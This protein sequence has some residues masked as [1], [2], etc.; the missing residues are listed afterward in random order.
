MLNL[1]TRVRYATRIMI[2]LAANR[3]SS[4][5]TKQEIAEAEAISADYVEQILMKLK[6]AGLVLS[7]R[8]KHG[9]FRLGCSPRDVSVAD[10]IRA[11]EGPI[12]LVPCVTDETCQRASF[13]AS[14]QVW[15]S[16]TSA[17]EKVLSGSMIG[18]L[19]D[20][21]RRMQTGGSMTFQI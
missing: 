11:V 2:Y 4:L 20:E 10:V 7:R 12:S 9:G 21:A 5:A 17:L 19:A 13:C 8:G 18:D 3:S 16:A 14:R 6:A 1:S 15:Q